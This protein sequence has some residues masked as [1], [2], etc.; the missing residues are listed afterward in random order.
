MKTVAQ[1][2][3]NAIASG[4]SREA[5]S[6][7]STWA[8]TY[9][10]MGKPYPGHYGFDHHPWARDMHD[11]EADLMVGMKAAQMGYTEVA[12]NKAFYTLDI[13][14]S[15]VL[16]VLPTQ[17][18]A[19]DFS[20]GRF[21]PALE[22]S[23]HLKTLFS[24]VKN[25]GMKTARNNAILYVRGARSKSQL[26][27]LPVSKVILDELDEMPAE[28][29]PLVFERVSG[30]LDHQIFMLSTPTIPGRGIDVYYQDS[31]QDHYFFPCPRCGRQTELIFPDCLIVTGDDPG[32]TDVL[33]SYIICNECK[34]PLDHKQKPDY[35]PKGHWVSGRTDRASRG[36]HINQLYSP[37]VAPYQLAIQLLE[38][39]V[40][41]AA[42]QELYNSKMGMPHTIE[43]AC[44]DDEMI[45]ACIVN[46]VSLAKPNPPKHGRLRT[47]GIDVGNVLHVVCLEWSFE[48]G[49]TGCYNSDLHKY[50]V[51][52]LI[53]ATKL[54]HF[55]QIPA[56]VAAMGAHFI[57]ID[58]NPEHRKG[59]EIARKYPGRVRLCYY[60]NNKDT[61]MIDVRDEENCG[62]H[63]SRTS[64]LDVVFARFKNKR[65][66]LPVD[67]SYEYRSN[68]KALTR[69]YENDRDGNPVGKYVKRDKDADHFA[70]ATLY[71]ELALV[72][73]YRSTQ[74]F[75]IT[76]IY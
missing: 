31:S 18:D 47:I 5:A 9:R 57:V 51:P 40:N 75:D 58:A 46:S 60:S 39:K 20:A 25:V 17:P 69:I 19:K 24:D 4:L 53:A 14:Q 43:G 3:A 42:E 36:Y 27:S 35:L 48:K 73:A 56:F 44:I 50:S 70:H 61:T 62:I 63:V 54:E 26:K 76:G 12:I 33:N 6:R 67:I 1:A 66:R 52:T 29:I 65:I 49:A 37:T 68:V 45:D 2:F 59:I 64:W 23:P 41:P 11:C 8:T 38:S 15:S 28:N 10:I 55:E 7:C 74:S 30:Q 71:G 21:D 16:Y 32:G 13:Q 34:Q 22:L 72:L